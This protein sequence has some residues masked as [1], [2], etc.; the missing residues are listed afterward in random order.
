MLLGLRATDDGRTLTNGTGLSDRVQTGKKRIS[1]HFRY[2]YRFDG[3]DREMPLGALDSIRSRFDATK[4]SPFGSCRIHSRRDMPK[5]TQL[6]LVGSSCK[7]IQAT[8]KADVAPLLCVK[9][10][11][12][13]TS[14]GAR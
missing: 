7:I 13:Y 10:S 8:R 2:R 12:V 11:G 6:R 14:L 1:V 9:V 5:A 4:L 3:N